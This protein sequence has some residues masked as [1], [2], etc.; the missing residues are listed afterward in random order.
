MKKPGALSVFTRT[1]I[2]LMFFNFLKKRANYIS[3]YT[4][5]DPDYSICTRCFG[6]SNI[7]ISVVVFNHFTGDNQV[8]SQD[9][10]TKYF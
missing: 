10:Y 2:R 8:T 6:Q 4:N 5:R 1:I 9:S 3:E 7:I